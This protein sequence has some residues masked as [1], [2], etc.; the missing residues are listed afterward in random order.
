MRNCLILNFVFKGCLQLQID[1]VPITKASAQKGTGTEVHSGEPQEA[2]Q[3]GRVP[4]T[5]NEQPVVGNTG[6]ATENCTQAIF[7]KIAGRFFEVLNPS[8]PEECNTFMDYLERARKVFP[9][10]VKS[11]S[12]II[13]VEVGSKEILEELWQDYQEGHLNQMAQKF[14]VT[15]KLLEEFGLIEFK[16]TTFIAEGEY[17]TCQHYFSGKLDK[18]ISGLVL[19]SVSLW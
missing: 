14:L 13:T 6:L 9:L 7:N 11:G 8:N 19:F 3:E 5:A 18:K 10:G 17:K 1:G 15:E 2:I 16:L 12:L 4:T